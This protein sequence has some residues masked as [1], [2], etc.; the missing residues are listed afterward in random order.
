MRRSICLAEPNVAVAGETRTWKFIYTPAANL[1]AGTKLKFDPQIHLRPVDWAEPTSNPKAKENAIWLVLPNE[2]IVAAKEI[3]SHQLQG[4]AFEFLLPAE[5]KAGESLTIC[6]GT[7]ETSLDA[8]RKLGSRAQSLTQRR[9]PFY[10]YIDPRGKGDYKDPEVF[11][12]DV[13]GGNLH[14]IRIIAPSLVSKNRRFDVLVRFEDQFG[15][16]TNQ[17]PEGML[18]ELSYEQ[19]RENLNW[20]LFVPETGFILLPNLYFNEVGV[21]RIQLRTSVGNMVFY[22]SPIKCLADSDQGIYW[23]LLHGESERADSSENTEAFLRHMRDERS[24]QFIAS[25]P[26]E[27]AEETSAEAWKTISTQIAEYNEENRFTTM[28]GFQWQGDENEGLRELIYWK[29]GKPILRK[30]DSKSSALKKIYKSHTPKELLSVICMPMAKGC[31]PNYDEFTPEYERLVEI[32]NAWGCSEC[33]AKEGNLRPIV[34]HGK[35][36]ISEVEKGSV[37]SALGRNIR[38]GFVAGGLDDRGFYESLYESDQVQYSPGLTAIIAI[39]QTRETLMQA[40]Y[41]RACYATTGSRIVLSFYIAGALMGSELTTK[42]KPGL[43]FNRHITG[44]ICADT[45]IKEVQI[46]RNGKV[47]HSFAPNDTNF[48]FAHDDSEELAKIVLNS[49]DERPPFIYYYLRVILKDGHMAFASPIWVD[50]TESI[51]NSMIKRTK[52]K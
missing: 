45:A 1:P 28:L 11:T 47:F 44:F 37:R 36:G 5:I 42:N 13:R 48:E 23:G 19:L 35:S 51:S 22:S 25:S 15:N 6:M 29:D 12:I 50:M 16:L 2:K 8:Q 49:P 20:K 26:F 43:A 18:I 33:T 39:E 34:T 4:H 24:L 7:H 14:L 32:Y 40:L 41:N 30:K 21:Y 27:D 3:A 46:I 52:K 9:R 31:V 38:F 17:A 10:L